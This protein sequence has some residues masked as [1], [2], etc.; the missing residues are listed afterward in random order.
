[1]ILKI[2]KNQNE[3]KFIT[4]ENKFFTE[5]KTVDNILI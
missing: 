1:M 4:I 2:Q 3:F 5:S